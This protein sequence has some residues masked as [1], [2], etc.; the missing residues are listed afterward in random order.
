M[1]EYYLA[2]TLKPDTIRAAAYYAAAEVREERANNFW[3]ETIQR[4]RLGADGTVAELRRDISAT[5]ADRLG[6]ANVRKPLTQDE[7]ANLLNARQIDGRLIE[8]R[9]KHSATRSVVEVFGLDPQQPPTAEVIRNVLAGKRADGKAPQSVCGKALSEKEIKGAQKRFKDALGI[10]KHREPTAEERAHLENG[11]LATGRF[12]DQAK[13][14][15]QIH[16]TR[17]PVGFIDMTF[18]ADKSLSIAW[19]LART[20]RER[21]ALLDIHKRAVA[22]TMTHVEAQLGFARKGKG[23]KDGVEPGELA[24]ISFDHFTA[25]PTV[26]IERHDKEGRAYTE[27]REVPSQTADPQLHTHVTVLNS[28]LTESGRIGAIDGDRLKGLVKE[29]GAVYQANVAT[30]ARKHGIETVLDERTGAARFTAIPDTVRVLFSKRHKEAEHAARE[31]AQSKGVDWNAATGEQKVAL[32]KAGAAETRQVKEGT[33]TDFAVWHEQA[34]G[35]S[36][37]HKTVWHT[38][39]LREPLADE[40]RHQ[41]AYRTALPMLEDRFKSNAVLDTQELREIAARA[42]IATGIGDAG[43]DIE[44]VVGM[45]RERGMMQDGEK[46]KLMWALAWPSAARNG[47]P[48]RPRCTSPRRRN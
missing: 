30:Y 28:V 41:A 32:L 3:Q 6:I 45:F 24:W 18:S 47:R 35:A 29:F 48:S 34:E 27:T 12:I 39:K 13:Y 23:G 7:I 15:R 17:P 5:M 8:G 14:R 40:E 42:L 33:K 19:A 10:P 36:Y 4:G 2:G 21:D 25:R 31:F 37:R 1:A 46:V 20:A 38:A 11:K 43:K 16:A 22:A 9:K 44:A 26:D